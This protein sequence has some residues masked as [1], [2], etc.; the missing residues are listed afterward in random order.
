LVKIGQTVADMAI[1]FN[2]SKMAAVRHFGFDERIWT[3]HEEYILGLYRYAKFGWNRHC[4]F[5]DM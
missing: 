2:F 4:S 3:T 5:E 1:F